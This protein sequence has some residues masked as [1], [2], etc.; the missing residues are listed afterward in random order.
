MGMPRRSSY[1]TLTDVTYNRSRYHA[2]QSASSPASI[3]IGAKC[4]GMALVSTDPC[5]TMRG[6]DHSDA[7]SLD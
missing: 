5:A 3:G 7:A 4:D 2:D 6:D 1:T